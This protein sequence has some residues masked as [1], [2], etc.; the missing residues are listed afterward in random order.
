[1][2]RPGMNRLG[3][4]AGIPVAGNRRM[5]WLWLSAAVLLV[6]IS[7]AFVDAPIAKLMQS[8]PG[9]LRVPFR[10]VNGLGKS[11]WY[12]VPGGLLALIAG[13]MAFRQ[14]QN[15]P[16]RLF[17]WL[18]AAGAYLFLAVAIPGLLVNLV[19]I[20]AGRARPKLLATEGFYGFEPFN[21]LPDFHSFPS[22]HSQ[23]AFCA[24][25]A[26]AA[27]WPRGRRALLFIAGLVAIARMVLGAHFLSDVVTS[28]LLAFIIVG[29]LERLCRDQRLVFTED[30][31]GNLALL[32]EGRWWRRRIR[33]SLCK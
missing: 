31:D 10:V 5:P 33:K 15:G 28:A 8:T 12:L 24:A 20:T 27:F 18:S 14:K 11:D 26:L 9:W 21:V 22:G 19:K 2:N 13:F 32:A 30:R 23:T 3:I 4:Q 1:M 17:R 7:M 25:L 16:R 6:L 29:W